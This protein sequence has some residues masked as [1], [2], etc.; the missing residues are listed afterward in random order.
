MINTNK[1]DMETR[2]I[3]KFRFV[4]KLHNGL[5]LQSELN[6][7]TSDIYELHLNPFNYEFTNTKKECVTIDFNGGITSSSISLP[8]WFVDSVGKRINRTGEM[9]SKFKELNLKQ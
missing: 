6:S 2:G 9:L 8:P 1:V 7:L 3:D 4:F 5:V